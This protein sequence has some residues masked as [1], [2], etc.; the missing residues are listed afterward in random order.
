[1]L[2]AGHQIKKFLHKTIGIFVVIIIDRSN[3]HERRWTH[4]KWIC[5]HPNRRVVM[6]IPPIVQFPFVFQ[7]IVEQG[8]VAWSA[9]DTS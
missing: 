8:I 1:V 5:V 6:M 3:V 4:Q 9:V 7:I 2:A